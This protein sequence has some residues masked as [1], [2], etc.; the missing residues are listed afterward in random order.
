MF[1]VAMFLHFTVT[2]FILIFFFTSLC[3]L[4]FA[5]STVTQDLLCVNHMREQLYDENQ[6]MHVFDALCNFLCG[7]SLVGQI[8]SIIRNKTV[9]H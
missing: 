8:Y 4:R 3:L 5:E 6:T 9:D 2:S 1:V 7:C